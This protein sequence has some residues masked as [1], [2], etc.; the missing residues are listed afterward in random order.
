MRLVSMRS[1]GALILMALCGGLGLAAQSVATVQI[2]GV[3]KD[4]SGATIPGAKVVATQTATQ[5]IRTTQT[6]A[7][8]AYA[9]TN[10]PIGPYTLQVSNPGFSTYRQTGIVLEVASN[11]TLN[12]TLQVGAQTQEVSVAANTA[13]V[14]T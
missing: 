8:G 10:L 13:M 7:H 12:V 2:S 1:V 14:E 5:F 11:P 4:A 6:G 3:V 9:L